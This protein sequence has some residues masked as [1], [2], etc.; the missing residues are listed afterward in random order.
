M[1]FTATDGFSG[2]ASQT[3]TASTGATAEGTGLSVDSPEFSDL[4]GNTTLAGAVP[5]GPFKV[6]LSDPTD[7][8]FV[9]GRRDGCVVLLRRGPGG[10]DRCTAVDLVSDL[11]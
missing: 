8:T 2:P 10:P 7:V 5:G 11:A 6:D 3:K 4:A 1:P 9:G